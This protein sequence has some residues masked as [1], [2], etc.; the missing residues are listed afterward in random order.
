MAQPVFGSPSILPFTSKRFWLKDAEA[1]ASFTDLS[2]I[3]T[4][5]SLTTKLGL[6]AAAKFR[7]GPFFIMEGSVKASSRMAVILVRSDLVVII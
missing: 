5:N 2:F 3:L 1:L 7:P 6:L 4:V